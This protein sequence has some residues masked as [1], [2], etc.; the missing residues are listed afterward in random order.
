[1]QP[2]GQ[3][4]EEKNGLGEKALDKTQTAC[5]LA[6]TKFKWGGQKKCFGSPVC[7]KYTFPGIYLWQALLCPY[8]S[9]L[10]F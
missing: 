3:S 7:W 5:P 10:V 6:K 8:G 1:M 9:K 4:F 2:T